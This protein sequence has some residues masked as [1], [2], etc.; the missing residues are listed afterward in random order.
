MKTSFQ[1]NW[2]D[3]FLG[4]KFNKNFNAELTAYVKIKNIK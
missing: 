1:D 2:K 4:L 3:V